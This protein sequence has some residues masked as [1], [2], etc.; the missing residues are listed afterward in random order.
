MS[1]MDGSHDGFIS[2][3]QQE[4]LSALDWQRAQSAVRH[5]QSLMDQR[6]SYIESHGLSRD[7]WMPA[8][9]WHVYQ[10][11]YRYVKELLGGN[12]LVMREMRE[13][14]CG[15]AG[16]TEHSPILIPPVERR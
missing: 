3:A 15:N 6:E 12:P 1:L 13:M 8:S 5:A 4:P 2:L 9:N 14:R 16:Q 7:V 11:F 10:P